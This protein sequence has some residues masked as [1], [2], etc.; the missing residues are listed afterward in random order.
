MFARYPDRSSKTHLESLDLAVEWGELDELG[1][2]S[3]W[4]GE[5]IEVVGTSS[6]SLHHGAQVSGQAAGPI[7]LIPYRGVEL[8]RVGKRKEAG[9]PLTKLVVPI[10]IDTGIHH[11]SDTSVARSADHSSS[12]RSKPST[13]DRAPA[14]MDGTHLTLA[15]TKSTGRPASS[16]HSLITHSKGVRPAVRP[17]PTVLNVSTRAPQLALLV[18]TFT[19]PPP[20]PNQLCGTMSRDD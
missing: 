3:W 10:R 6:F 2:C 1:G 15:L 8:R 19:R 20:V 4:E 13:P 7:A 17:P 18:R 16:P 5:V 11:H 12:T 14:K 9:S